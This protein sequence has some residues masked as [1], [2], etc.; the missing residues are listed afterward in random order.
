MTESVKETFSKSS[1]RN[2]YILRSRK[3]WPDVETNYCMASDLVLTT[4]FGLHHYLSELGAEVKYLDHLIDRD[5]MEKNNYIVYSFFRDWFKNKEGNDIFQYHG[6]AFG[7]AFRISI[8]SELLGYVRLRLNLEALHGLLY[9]SIII[10]EEFTNIDEITD[11]LKKTD[12]QYSLLNVTC[13][14]NTPIYSFPIKEWVSERL[15]KSSWKRWLRNEFARSQNILLSVVDMFFGFYKKQSSIFIQNYYP[16]SDLISRLQRTSGIQIIQEQIT[17][18]WNPFRLL[19]ERMIPTYG[20]PVRFQSQADIL[21]DAFRADRCHRVILAGNCD[22]TDEVFQVIEKCLSPVLAITLRDLSCVVSY[23]ER[24]GLD[25]VVLIAN[26]GKISALMD[27]YAKSKEI[28]VYLIANGIFANNFLDESKYATV[29]NGYSES[30]K[31]NY[32]RGMDNVVC[33]GDPRMDQYPL[34]K[35]RSVNRKNP[36]ITVGASGF[37]NLDLNSY[38]AVEFDFM[39]DVLSSI[40]DF[41]NRIGGASVRIK[42]RANAYKWQYEQFVEEYFPSFIS[43]VFHMEPFQE[44]LADTDLFISINSQTIFEASCSGIPSIYYKKDN[45]FLNPPW[46]GKSEVVMTSSREELDVALQDFYTGSERFTQFLNRQTMEQYVGP[47]DGKN[48]ERNYDQV[49][50]MLDR[51][52]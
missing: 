1:Y 5:T 9:G 3:E 16:T 43:R 26:L 23:F 48:L 50:K 38:L 18:R 15:N 24:N 8:L 11:I 22:I 7:F 46:D 10:S 12:I 25:L 33:L 2:I 31:N 29:I 49:L 40:K 51:S 4:D 39:F 19:R 41:S 36:V 30:V 47:L 45:E 17:P 20:S 21:M 27:C 44:L 13:M 32:F 28:P 34:V 6:I 14:R 35:S 42:V 52:N 37:N